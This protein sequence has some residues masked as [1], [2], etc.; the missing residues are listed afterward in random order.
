MSSLMSFPS[1]VITRVES[2]IDK[3]LRE[4]VEGGLVELVC[5]IVVSCGVVA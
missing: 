1:G 4:P 3:W 5:A 2:P